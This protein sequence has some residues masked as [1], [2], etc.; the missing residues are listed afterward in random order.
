MGRLRQRGLVGIVQRWLSLLCVFGGIWVEK[1]L[2]FV[3]WVV[4][5]CL[6]RR[7]GLRRQPSCVGEIVES[8][9]HRGSLYTDPMQHGAGSKG[10]SPQGSCYLAWI[11]GWASAATPGRGHRKRLRTVRL[12]KNQNAVLSHVTP[13]NIQNIRSSP[14]LIVMSK[15]VFGLSL[16]PLSL[17]A[18]RERP[19]QHGRG[20]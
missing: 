10:E 5:H 9:V 18:S 20:A 11:S 14:V 17:L 16:F 19:I 8:V 12:T 6:V 7:G 4:R 2:R 1:V 15:V 3:R 13:I